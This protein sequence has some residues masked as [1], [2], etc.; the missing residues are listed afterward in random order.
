MLYPIPHATALVHALHC[1]MFLCLDTESDS[2]LLPPP[3]QFLWDCS[4]AH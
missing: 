3:L 1:E 2:G 4:F